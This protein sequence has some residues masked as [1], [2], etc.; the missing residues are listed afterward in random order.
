MTFV[1]VRSAQEGDEEPAVLWAEITASINGAPEIPL[2]ILF[3][4]VALQDIPL[5]LAP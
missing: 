5:R 1:F 2:G 4:V 3:G